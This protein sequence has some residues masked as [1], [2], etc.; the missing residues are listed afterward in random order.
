M[1]AYVTQMFAYAFLSLTKQDRLKRNINIRCSQPFSDYV[2][3]Q[4]LDNRACSP[5]ISY[6]KNAEQIDKNPLNF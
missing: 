3:L 2:P 1:F 6:D 5:K 4:H